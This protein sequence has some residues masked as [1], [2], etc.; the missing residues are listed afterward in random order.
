MQARA[1]VV[2]A[3]F[4]QAAVQATP[5]IT[6][7]AGVQIWQSVVSGICHHVSRSEGV[8]L[9]R[10]AA[11]VPMN[12]SV[13]FTDVAFATNKVPVVPKLSLTHAAS[14]AGVDRGVVAA[15]VAAVVQA[16]ADAV[17]RGDN[18]RLG[19]LPLGE[20][21]CTKG[22]VS[23][24][25]QP[26]VGRLSSAKLAPRR[27]SSS[28]TSGISGR[29]QDLCGRPESLARPATANTHVSAAT[30]AIAQ[31][32]PLSATK[33]AARPA[34]AR[35]YRP[36]TGGTPRPATAS[37][38]ASS[39]RSHL[40]ETRT[41][42]CAV[43]R[44][45]TRASNQATHDTPP[46]S[47]RPAS[48][49]AKPLPVSPTDGAVALLARVKAVLVGRSG[50]QAGI[51]TIARTMRALDANRDGR[52]S[53]DELRFGLRDFGV[54]CAAV[55]I[56]TIM[57]ALDRDRDGTVSFD[58]FLVALR[59]PMAPSRLAMISLAFQKLDADGDG[60]VTLADV[61]ELYD[62]SKHPAVLSGEKAPDDVLAAFMEQWDTDENDGAVTL[63]EFEHYYQ[64]VSASIDD[65]AYFELMMRNAWR[66]PG[67]VGQCAN[68]ANKRVLVQDAD[69]NQRVVEATSTPRTR[70]ASGNADAF[71]QRLEDPLAYARHV[72][73]EPPC[74]IDALAHRVGA[75]R[76]LGSGQERVHLKAFATALGRRDKKL[77][78]R[79]ALIIARALAVSGSEMIDIPGLHAQFTS[80]FG[81]PPRAM[82]GA[83]GNVLERLK[84]KIITRG[85]SAGIHA[86]QRVMRLW[87]SERSDGKLTKDELKAGL[88]SY[89]IEIHLHEVDQL[90]TLLD[91]DHSGAVSFD[92]L[93]TGLRGQLNARR[94]ALVDQ[95]YALLDETGDGRVT[96]DDLRACYDVSRHPDVMAGRLSEREA[97]V[98]FLGN[99]DRDGDGT[100]SPAEFAAYYAA[101]SASIDGDD[102]FELMMRNAWHISGGTGQCANSSNQRVLV[103]HADGHQTVEEIKNDLRVRSHQGRLDNLRRQNLSVASMSSKGAALDLR[104]RGGGPV[105]TRQHRENAHTK[106]LA[107][108]HAAATA[109]QRRFRAFRSCKFAR[110]V[111]R[112]MAATKAHAAQQAKE[113]AKSKPAVL[114]PALRTYHGF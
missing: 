35:T 113:A 6:L 83:T 62:V 71:A 58:E 81:A 78:A 95:A 73:F 74:T 48:G 9:E 20:W 94:Q 69:G 2:T 10:F 110:A 84:A 54:D 59:G 96:L 99:W 47:A 66:I 51:H 80:R 63:A 49:G 111:R 97:L 36:S 61:R 64:N 70:S 87:D 93:L 18:V 53:R 8:R 43:A 21:L 106:M 39:A 107:E 33:S 105:P 109:I 22:R 108:R 5:G 89:G 88:E 98:Q 7:P 91:T 100:V 82:E 37:S 23:F 55:D 114:R 1:S 45:A 31:G 65:D 34:T 101:V 14:V 19:F 77:S 85:G 68:S 41:G 112:K 60:V 42:S 75:N 40:S 50:D 28:V 44:T 30:K 24:E 3:D 52:L 92:E 11:F 16:V 79:D 17:D 25:F 72:L 104:Q 46:R 76:V 67:G 57:G 4:V 103:T 12:G 32:R 29:S 26:R 90:M 38:A 102:Y 56:D 15:F 86:V 13:I 27:S